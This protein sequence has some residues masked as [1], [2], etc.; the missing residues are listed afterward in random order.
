ME[1]LDAQLPDSLQRAFD[2]CARAHRLSAEAQHDLA[3]I[4]DRAFAFGNRHPIEDD[5]VAVNTNFG[6]IGIHSPEYLD[7]VERWNTDR[8]IAARESDPTRFRRL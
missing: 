3:R 5:R 2:R 4:V 1:L 8:A 7:A 6:P